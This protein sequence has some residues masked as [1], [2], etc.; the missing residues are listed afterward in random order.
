LSV[1]NGNVSQQVST[2]RG[3]AA[4]GSGKVTLERA[5]NGGT[6]SVDARTTSGTAISGTIKCDAF[7]PHMAEG[8]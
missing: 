5:G 6:F 7:A 8:G 3:G 2:V 1:T 4:T